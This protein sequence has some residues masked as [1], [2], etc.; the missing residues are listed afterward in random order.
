[1]LRIHDEGA[2][3]GVNPI[4]ADFSLLVG[5]GE[6]G[7]THEDA[8][9]REVF[10][11]TGIRDV[12]IGPW[13]WKREKVITVTWAGDTV[14]RVFERFYLA[15]HRCGQPQEVR[16]RTS[17]GVRRCHVRTSDWHWRARR[18]PGTGG[19]PRPKSWIARR[20]SSSFRQ[21]LAGCSAI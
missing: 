20:T 15:G 6:A 3:R 21:V 2:T 8:A 9:P 18:S 7:E 12:E 13:L 10:E 5:G 19:G 1:M 16:R 14:T 4:V 17:P 11:E